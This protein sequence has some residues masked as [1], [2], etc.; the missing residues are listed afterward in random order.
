MIDGVLNGR[1]KNKMEKLKKLVLFRPDVQHQHQ[2][3]QRKYQI[4][5]EI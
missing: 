3:Q 4:S 2:H 5:F 1:A